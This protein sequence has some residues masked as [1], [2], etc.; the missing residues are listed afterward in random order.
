MKS[1]GLLL[2]LVFDV[3]IIVILY[4]IYAKKKEIFEDL[5]HKLAYLALIITIVV[6]VPGYI[7]LTSD[8]S[9]S[10]NV[11]AHVDSGG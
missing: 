9:D 4:I 11:I 7:S 1:M 3:I 6:A 10:L 5:N 8:E 2:A